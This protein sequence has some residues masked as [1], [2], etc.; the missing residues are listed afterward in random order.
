MTSKEIL[1]SN[2]IL[3]RCTWVGLSSDEYVTVSRTLIFLQ[4]SLICVKY[5]HAQPRSN[6]FLY[7]TPRNFDDVTCIISLS[8]ISSFRSDIE[9]TL[10]WERNKESL[11]ERA[12]RLV[13]HECISVI[14]K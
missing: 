3:V 11:K 13:R 2:T 4:F 10:R 1:K 6:A 12:N 9:T 8:S 7:N 5:M 14:S